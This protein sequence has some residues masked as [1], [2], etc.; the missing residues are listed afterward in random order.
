MSLSPVFWLSLISTTKSCNTQLMLVNHWGTPFWRG[1]SPSPYGL[2]C[3]LFPWGTSCEGRTGGAHRE[4]GG[5]GEAPHAPTCA[6]Q[7]R[8]VLA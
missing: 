4:G 6:E 5:E 2:I 1:K 8:E 3:F 7:H